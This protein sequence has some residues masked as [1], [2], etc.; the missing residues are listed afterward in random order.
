MLTC[1]FLNKQT[2]RQTRIF[3]SK[4]MLDFPRKIYIFPNNYFTDTYFS[5]HRVTCEEITEELV[6]YPLNI[7]LYF[8]DRFDLGKNESY[9]AQSLMNK[10]KQTKWKLVSM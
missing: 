5:I 8:K 2:K 10:V 1:H 9:Q 3:S 7:P 6:A 4:E